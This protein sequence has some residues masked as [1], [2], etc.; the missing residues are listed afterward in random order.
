[1]EEKRICECGQQL[2]IKRFK[3]TT[4]LYCD[5]CNR[6]MHENNPCEHKHV[7]LKIKTSN[8]VIQIRLFC[9]KCYRLDGKPHKHSDYNLNELQER[10]LSEYNEF[11][12]KLC[13]DDKNDIN[14]FISSI[15]LDKREKYRK[16]LLSERWLWI[17]RAVLD[18]DKYRCQICGSNAE[19]VHHLTYEHL[20]NEFLFELVS[21]CRRCHIENYHS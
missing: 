11:Y 21:L 17:R 2:T 13:E 19:E 16:Y 4:I 12:D 15:R 7:P 3:Y 20:E 14:S 18:R 5:R 8:G 6:V 9:E 10:S 1:M